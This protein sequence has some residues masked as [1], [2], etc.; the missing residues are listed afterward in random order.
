[1]AI[2][3]FRYNNAG[4]AGREMAHRTFVIGESTFTIKQDFKA[5]GK[6]GTA[7]GFGANVYNSSFV[8]ADYVSQHLA[9]RVRGARVVELGCGTGLVSIACGALGAAEVHATDG[10]EELLALTAHNI[11]LNGMAETV[12]TTCLMWGDE[13]VHR[14]LAPPVDM[15]L[16]ADVAAFVY[17]SAFGPLVDSL[18]ALSSHPDGEGRSAVVLLAYERRHGKERSFFEKLEQNFE[19][20]QVGRDKL[21]RDFQ[22]EQLLGS[23]YILELTPLLTSSTR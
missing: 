9:E 21:H 19:V 23:I 17:E 22:E 10:D 14:E 13:E 8:L 5:D 15:V 16:A 6:G 12:R 1:M 4:S 3:P 7:L 20:H 18:K 2:V 11:E